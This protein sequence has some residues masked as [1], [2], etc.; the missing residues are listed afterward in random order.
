MVCGILLLAALFTGTP[1][2]QELNLGNDDDIV[3]EKTPEE[4]SDEFFRSCLKRPVISVDQ[5]TD[6]AFCACAANNFYLWNLSPENIDEDREFYETAERK[7]LNRETLLTDIYASCLY[8]PR[9]EIEYWECM[10]S[11]KHDYYYDGQLT[12]LCSC[13]AEGVE[14]YYRD[15]AKPFLELQFA[16][17]KGDRIKS[18]IKAIEKD[19]SFYDNYFN[20]ETRCYTNLRESAQQ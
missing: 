15:L 2:A 3:L 8:I 5:Q 20:L 17:G 7:E 4:R 16:Q 10:N 19:M 11:E 18:P 14:S 6:E 13:L 1:Q 9:S 12:G